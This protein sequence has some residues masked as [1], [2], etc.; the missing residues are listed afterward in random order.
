MLMTDFFQQLPTNIVTVDFWKAMAPATLTLGCL[1]M[2]IVIISLLIRTLLKFPK[3]SKIFQGPPLSF[4]FPTKIKEILIPA[5]FYLLAA[6]VLPSL[7]IVAL[8][9]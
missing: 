4:L 9:F 3:L 2:L 7:A 5:L 8:R 6:F 1:H